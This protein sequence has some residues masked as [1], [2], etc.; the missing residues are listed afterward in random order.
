MTTA[1]ESICVYD[2]PKSV[3]DNAAQCIASALT[4]NRDWMDHH[5]PD[6]K[7]ADLETAHRILKQIGYDFMLKQM[8]SL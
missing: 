8:G 3:I 1:Q 7:A 6:A 4:L 5:E 2:E